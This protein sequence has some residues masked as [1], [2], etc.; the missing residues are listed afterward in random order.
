MIKEIIKSRKEE[1]HD[2][3]DI[4]TVFYIDIKGFENYIFL[5]YESC[6]KFYADCVNNG[7]II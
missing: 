7:T 1:I 6:L 4:R 5:N 2:K 3:Y